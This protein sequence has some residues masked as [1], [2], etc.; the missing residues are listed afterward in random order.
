MHAEASAYMGQALGLGLRELQ[1]LAVQ[2]EAVELELPAQDF[3]LGAAGTGFAFDNELGAHG[4]RVAA[5]RIDAHPVRWARFLPFVEA[6]GYERPEYWDEAG[7]AWLQGQS[8]RQPLYLRHGGAGWEQRIGARWQTLQMDR[9][10]VHI[11]A[12]EAQ[13]WCRW[14]GRQLPTEAQWECAALTLPGFSWGEVWEWTASPFEPYPAF[15]AHPYRDYSA[16]WFG[17]RRVLRGACAATD[18]GLA[19]ARYRNFFEPQRRD[20]FAGFRSCAPA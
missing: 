7:R 4:V 1:P 12:H 8:L 9:P 20:V 15:V 17:T 2:P 14:A 11:T 18:P 16:P 5:A 3:V 10:V 6:G 13:A 19:R